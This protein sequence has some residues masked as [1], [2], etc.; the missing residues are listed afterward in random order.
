MGE[1]TT[2]APSV[3]LKERSKNMNKQHGWIIMMAIMIYIFSGSAFATPP[4]KNPPKHI[5]DHDTVRQSQGQEQDQQQQMMQEQSQS[6]GQDQSQGQSQ[7]ANQDNDQT[8][9]FGSPKQASSA[10]APAVYSSNPCF[11][12]KSGA[13]GFDRVNLGRGKQQ[14]DEQCELREVVRLLLAAEERELAVT[15]LCSSD[16]A[17]VL[18]DTCIP[19]KNKQRR[20]NSLE[21]HVRILQ[22][23][24]KINHAKCSEAKDRLLQGCAK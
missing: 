11:Y 8:I 16:A 17:N 23:E 13:I 2:N 15:L 22:E 3:Q 6:Q 21:Q 24:R 19:H 10:I 18:G 12:G 1:R 9:S 4:N 14:R 7:V 5:H 20:I